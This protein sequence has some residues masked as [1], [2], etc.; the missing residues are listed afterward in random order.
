MADVAEFMSLQPGIQNGRH[1][2]SVCVDLKTI[3]LAIFF[4]LKCGVLEANRLEPRSGPT[5]VGPDLGSLQP[6]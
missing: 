2:K 1:E 4:S 5:Y 3:F 6:V